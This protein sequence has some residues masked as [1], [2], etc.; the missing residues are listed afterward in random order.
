MI[1]EHLEDHPQFKSK[2]SLS[3]FEKEREI[4]YYELSTI[5]KDFRLDFD[6]AMIYNKN[7]NIELTCDFLYNT[8][9]IKQIVCAFGHKTSWVGLAKFLQVSRGM[10]DINFLYDTMNNHLLSPV[11]GA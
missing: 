6:E 4:C 7:Y 1:V 10:D 11:Y 2:V 9:M 3:P 5:E 8:R